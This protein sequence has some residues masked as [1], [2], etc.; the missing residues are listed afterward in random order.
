V[1][2]SV[3]FLVVAALTVTAPRLAQAKGGT[4][5]LFSAQAEAGTTPH[6]GIPDPPGPSNNWLTGCGHGRYRDPRTSKCVG[7]ADFSR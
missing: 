7:P 6:T 5:H 4:F 2:R 3:L 1:G